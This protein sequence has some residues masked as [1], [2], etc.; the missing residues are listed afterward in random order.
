M[1]QLGVG[2]YMYLALVLLFSIGILLVFFTQRRQR[3]HLENFTDSVVGPQ[4][5]DIVVNVSLMGRS[6]S[7]EL[8]K[9][10]K[11]LSKNISSLK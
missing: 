5:G 4:D 6:F 2:L 9:I 10:A 7:K 8:G 1:E 3:R 11:E